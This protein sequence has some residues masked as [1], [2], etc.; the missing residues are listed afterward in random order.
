MSLTGPMKPTLAVRF[1]P[2][3]FELRKIPRQNTEKPAGKSLM[4]NFQMHCASLSFQV[5]NIS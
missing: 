2:V 5:Q 4:M 3:L 1:C